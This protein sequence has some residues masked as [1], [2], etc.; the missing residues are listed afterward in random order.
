MVDAAGFLLGLFYI[1]V[2]FGFIP[3]MIERWS[4]ARYYEKLDRKA[5]LAS[6]QSDREVS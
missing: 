3:F 6:E 5:S 4:V 1:F 2:V